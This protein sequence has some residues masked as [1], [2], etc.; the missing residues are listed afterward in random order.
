MRKSG[1]TWIEVL[2]LV[3]L[4]CLLVSILLPVFQR[5]RKPV[6]QAICLS[7]MRSIA[8][9]ASMY[10]EDN[11]GLFP[12]P[13]LDTPEDG[14]IRVLA[15][16]ARDR[17]LYR[18]PS[19]RS[20]DWI[21][22]GDLPAVRL[23]NDRRSSY[24]TNVYISPLQ[25]PPPGAPDPRPRYGYLKR[26]LIPFPAE[27]VYLAECAETEG[28]QAAT[29]VIH[30]DQWVPC[31]LTRLP[32]S[33]AGGEIALERHQHGRENYTY[34]DGHAQ[35]ASFEATFAYDDQWW[36]VVHDQWNPAFRLSK[37]ARR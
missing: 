32:V 24:A 30:A 35:T 9:A 15:P 28:K 22:P 5:V 25:I 14:W 20:D 1:A 10:S 8:L 4:I 17:L 2:I 3:M 23:M 16:Y 18:C 34:A 12:V 36:E 27:T 31:R 26:R 7:N 37:Y 6:R 13:G 33:V 29:R 21:N 19:D 11:D